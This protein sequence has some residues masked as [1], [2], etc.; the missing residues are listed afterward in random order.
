VPTPIPDWIPAPALPKP[1]GTFSELTAETLGAHGTDQDGFSAVLDDVL[2]AAQSGSDVFYANDDA[3]NAAA[4]A[5]DDVAVDP[6]PSLPADLDNYENEYSRVFAA[7]LADTGQVAPGQDGIPGLPTGPD[8]GI[9]PDPGDISKLD[10]GQR[11]VITVGGTIPGPAGGH[12]PADVVGTPAEK[13]FGKG[14]PA[15]AAVGAGHLISINTDGL[16]T[17]NVSH[18]MADPI[19]VFAQQDS[20]APALFGEGHLGSSSAPWL[21]VKGSTFTFSVQ[22]DGKEIDS[23]T[24]GPL[25]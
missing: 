14:W 21:F 12:G 11:T 9:L 19:Q 7:F 16:V 15:V 24:V 25:Q 1:E 6:D 4:F 2:G 5:A 17:W 18:F 20:N 8:T 3:L 13:L 10:S 23:V 22:S